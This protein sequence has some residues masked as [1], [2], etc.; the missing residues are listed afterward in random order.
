MHASLMNETPEAVSDE[1][2]RTIFLASSVVSC[3]EAWGG[4][5]LCDYRA[6]HWRR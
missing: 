5:P 2:D 1:D 3:Q 4:I 6:H